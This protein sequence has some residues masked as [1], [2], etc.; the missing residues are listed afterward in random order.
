EIALLIPAGPEA[1][2][3]RLVPDLEA[4]ALHLRPAE[5][6]FEVAD[7][8]ADQGRPFTV[9]LWRRAV[10]GVVEDRLASAREGSRHEADLDEGLHA[11]AQD[12]LID[13]VDFREIVDGSAVDLPVDVRVSEDAV[14][15][16]VLKADF[17]VDHAKLRLVWGAQH[18][19]AVV[20]ADTIL[21]EHV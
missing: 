21:P 6:R 16:H 12:R 14:K 20:R 7:E 19:R 13:G 5:T 1:I 11:G 8:G 2:Q 17:P 10:R 3:I 18:E 4:P 9:V 15:A